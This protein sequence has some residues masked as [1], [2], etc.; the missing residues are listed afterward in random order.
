SRGSA[1]SSASAACAAR[2][3]VRPLAAS[4]EPFLR[5]DLS[6]AATLAGELGLPLGPLESAARALE[7]L[8][9]DGG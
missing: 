4:A 5:K 8:F 9:P 3:G 7:E 1:A 2:G 6:V